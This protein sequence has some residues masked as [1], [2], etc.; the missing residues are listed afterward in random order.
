[1]LRA[2]PGLASA[3][4]RYRAIY[5]RA[6]AFIARPPADCTVVHV[7]PGKLATTRTTRDPTILE[8]DYQQGRDAGVRA[9]AAWPSAAPRASV[10]DPA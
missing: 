7:A 1:M 10:R 4:R 3:F 5:A 8:A 6:S 2:S 9:I